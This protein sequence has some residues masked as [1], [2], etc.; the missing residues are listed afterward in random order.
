MKYPSFEDLA[1]V[2][3]DSARLKRD[4]R[5]DP[6]TQICRDLGL[7]GNIGIKVLKAI[8]SHYK[9]ALKAELFDRI[10]TCRSIMQENRDEIPVIQSLLGRPIPEEAPI[11]LG[12]LYKLVLQ[13][14]HAMPTESQAAHPAN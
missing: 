3:R 11:T 14:L 13:E 5:I 8:E 10:E 2:T 6:D 4:T 1:R 12:Q 7:S 9:I